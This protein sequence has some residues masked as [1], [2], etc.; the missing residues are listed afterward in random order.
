MTAIQPYQTPLLECASLEQIRN[1]K[2]VLSSLII[3]LSSIMTQTGTFL[4]LIDK[5]DFLWNMKL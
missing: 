4:P 5:G 2:P 1:K 3:S